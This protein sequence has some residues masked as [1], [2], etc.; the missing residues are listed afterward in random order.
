MHFNGAKTCCLQDCTP[1]LHKSEGE[2]RI[3]RALIRRSGYGPYEIRCQV[4]L[5][6]RY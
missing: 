4:F 1:D 5:R 2:A 3:I 6:N